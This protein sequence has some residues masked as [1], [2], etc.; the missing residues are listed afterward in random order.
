MEEMSPAVGASGAPT[1]QA[2]GRATRGDHDVT[3][4]AGYS[5]LDLTVERGWLCGRLLADLG[6]SV[7]KVEP[8]SGDPGRTKGLF[9]DPARPDIEENLSWWFQNRGKS[10]L[11]LDLD[12]AA[13]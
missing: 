12:D 5:V 13:D 11:V 2:T 6:A 3:A 10:S 8:P 1:A 4:L 7:I 9:A